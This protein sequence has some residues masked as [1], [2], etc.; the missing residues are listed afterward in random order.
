MKTTSSQLLCLMLLSCLI[1]CGQELSHQLD[2]AGKL[3]YD[4]PDKALSLLLSIDT[5]EIVSKK[6]RAKYALLLSA[7]MDKNY[8]DVTSDSLISVAVDF[9]AHKGSIRERMLAWYYYGIVL[10]ND[11]N[12]AQAI[13]AFEKAETESRNQEDDLYLGLI[14]RNKADIYCLT[15]NNIEAIEAHQNAIDDF[16]RAGASLYRDYAVLALAIDY[17]NNAELDKA[18]SLLSYLLTVAD[19]SALLA[20]CRMRKASVFVK[21]DIHPELAIELYQDVPRSFFGILDYTY[22]AHAFEMLGQ[23]DSADYW[24][25]EGYSKCKDQLDSASLDYMKS[26]VEMKRGHFEEAFHLVD[27]AAAVQDSLARILFRQSVN[28][29]LRDYYKGETLLKEEKIHSM[30]Q[31]V[32]FGMVLG[33]LIVLLLVMSI[34][35]TA[36]NK[37][38]LLKEQ[39]AKL[40]LKERE[41]DRL[42]RDNA[43]LI[44]SLFSEKIDHLDLLCESYFKLEDGKQ[45]DFVFKQ[46]KELTA[47]IRNDDSLFISL[48]KDLDRYCNN[49]MSALRKQVPRIKGE[50]LKIISLFFAGFSYE[51][52]QFILRKN[53]TQSLR[54]ARSRFRKEIIE[55]EA[56]DADSFIKMLE[57]KKRPQAGT[58]E[59]MGVC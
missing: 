17:S 4:S 18:D 13:L 31:R 47:K 57:I 49:I 45:K 15:N 12:Y 38:R 1:S 20:Q 27:H 23:K 11:Q 28:G 35:S 26:R 55:A 30:R 2:N 29:A 36:H 41:I 19:D 54:T 48:E 53:S 37:D 46:V 6:D 42:N 3:L 24:L 25:S 9:Y 33:L 21:K 14:L 52:I 56:P 44:G 51:T 22:L 58:N 7:A 59:N 5:Q 43:H 8:Y 34:I 16:D 10:K 39:M 32:S 50:N 40:A